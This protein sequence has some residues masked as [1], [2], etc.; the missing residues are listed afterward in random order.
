M[1]KNLV[2]LATNCKEFIQA[3]AAFLMEKE[4]ACLI[5]ANEDEYSLYADED[6]VTE[7]GM[8]AYSKFLEIY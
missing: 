7:E 6:F 1:K 5:K 8:D 4:V 2:I 3:F